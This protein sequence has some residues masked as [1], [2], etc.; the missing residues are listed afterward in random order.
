[1]CFYQLPSKSACL[2]EGQPGMGRR[3]GQPELAAAAGSRKSSLAGS[4]FSDSSV[5]FW[6]K[7]HLR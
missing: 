5:R 6:K 4:Q 3:A 2:Q 1:M 7:T